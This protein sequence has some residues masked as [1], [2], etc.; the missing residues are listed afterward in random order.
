MMPN[1]L[2]GFA[3]LLTMAVACIACFDR[4]TTPPPTLK[5]TNTPIPKSAHHFFAYESGLQHTLYQVRFSI[6]Q[7]DVA[8][9]A[10]PCALGP[11]ATGSAPFATVGTN[12]RWWY[13]PEKARHHRGCDFPR[14]GLVSGSVL[15]DSTSP[16]DPTV[17]VVV[18]VE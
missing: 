4:P 8:Q 11:P 3:A 5:F 13:T 12:D 10:L 7:A 6:P 14:A 2:L 9:L 16:G 18:A 15:V 1:R 17:F